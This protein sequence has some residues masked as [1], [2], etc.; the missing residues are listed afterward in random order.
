MKQKDNA[1]QKNC[2]WRFHILYKKPGPIPSL[3]KSRHQV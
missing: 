3:V 2:V 1:E